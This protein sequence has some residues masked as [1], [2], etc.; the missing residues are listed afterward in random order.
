MEAC[1]AMG[2]RAGA[3]RLYRALADRLQEE[4]GIGPGEELR[5]YYGQIIV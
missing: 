3:L 1:L 5:A 2:D 4:L